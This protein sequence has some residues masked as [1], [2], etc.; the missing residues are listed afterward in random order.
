V[1]GGE[2]EELTFSV[3]ELEEGV[4]LETGKEYHLTEKESTGR[5][6]FRLLDEGGVTPHPDEVFEVQGP[7]DFSLSGTTDADGVFEHP[8]PIRFGDYTLV[9]GETSRVIHPQAEGSPPQPLS[10]ADDAIEG[11]TD[12]D[13]SPPDDEEPLEDEA[14]LVEIERD[15]GDPAPALLDVDFE[16]V[17]KAVIT[18]PSLEGTYSWSAGGSEVSVTPVEGSPELATVKGVSETGEGATVE[19]KCT[20]APSEANIAQGEATHELEVKK[21]IVEIH[22][23]R[24]PG[25]SDDRGIEGLDFKV[26]AEGQ[27][28]QTGTTAAD[29]KIEVQLAGD[30][31]TLTLLYEDAPV[32]V[33]RVTQR[34]E[35][36]EEVTLVRGQQRRLRGRG[37][38]IGEGGPESDGVDGLA[39]PRTSRAILEFQADEGLAMDGIVGSKTQGAL[40]G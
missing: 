14:P 18:P 35:E 19:I 10:I 31:T 5:L 24:S 40:E 38:P 12:H 30:E 39:G 28:L 26:E 27:E 29:G 2:R 11:G 25:V 34:A 9:V 32:A 36:P 1:S 8:E 4:A 17:L 15:N 13:G 37:Y 33:Y 6:A 7:D 3:T 22:L 23:Q 20:F 16:R 21:R